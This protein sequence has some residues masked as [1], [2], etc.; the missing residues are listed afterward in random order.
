M[1]FTEEQE[2]E[3]QK[4]VD[5]AARYEQWRVAFAQAVRITKPYLAGMVDQINPET[6]E[7]S[8]MGVI[9]PFVFHVFDSECNKILAE[10][11]PQKEEPTK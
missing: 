5:E 1:E 3:I 6:K 2:A 10:Y 9:D 8:K 11:F 4:R 7:L